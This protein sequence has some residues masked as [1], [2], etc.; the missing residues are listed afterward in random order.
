M[1]TKRDKRT[2]ECPTCKKHFHPIRGRFDIQVFCK[3]ICIRRTEEFKKKVSKGMIGVNTWARGRKMP[4]RAGAKSHFWK[5]GVSKI[6]RTKRQ[7]I[8]ST[9]EYKEFRRTIFAR[10]NYTCQICGDRTKKGHKIKIQIDHI[11]PFRF[12]PELYM[13]EDN[14]RTVCVPCHYKTDT[15]GAKVYR[16]TKKSLSPV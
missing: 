6:N 10:D 12:Y 9:L 4:D 13:K 2:K 14:A 3:N 16:S 5:G 11:K 8:D 15:Y 1:A 7:N